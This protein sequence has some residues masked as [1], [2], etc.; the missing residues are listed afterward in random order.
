MLR[1]ARFAQGYIQQTSFGFK[2]LS[3]GYP[4]FKFSSAGIEAQYNQ[5][6]E[7]YQEH[8]KQYRE[9]MQKL[10]DEQNI[11][12]KK[13]LAKGYVHPYNSDHHPI[14]FSAVK[15]AELFYD[16]VGPEQVS[17]H[18]ENYLMS[19]KYLM[20][21]FAMF[22]TLNFFMGSY[23]AHYIAASM[24]N[25][26]LFWGILMYFYVELRKSWFKPLLLRFYRR[27][28]S[29]DMYNM[30]AYWHENMEH[31]VR[32]LSRLC[33]DQMQYMQVHQQFQGIKAESINLFMANE[34]ANLQK[35][36][37]DRALNLLRNAEQYEKLNKNKILQEIMNNATTELDR[38]L[39]GAERE[40]INN[41][42]FESALIGL[43]EGR[44]EYK[45]DPILPIVQSYIREN[46]NKYTSM[47]PEEQKKLTTLTEHQWESLKNMDN[48]AKE[49]YLKA[50]PKGFD[51]SL[52]NHDTVRQILSNWGN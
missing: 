19:R 37:H 18:Y 27:V 22:A 29:Q 9:K 34:Y 17:P 41:Q 35:H 14:N 40:Q 23:D 24:M 46:A 31:R 28:S 5:F 4:L 49:E 42:M 11:H 36:L 1:Q 6:H 48:Q 10:E 7:Q 15:L 39:N 38:Q 20:A 50:E 52:K 43:A 47:S 3:A 45:Q 33:L 51:A 2:N 21:F 8:F 25:P 13:P 16:F 26:L 30:Q 12:I 32:N 44:M